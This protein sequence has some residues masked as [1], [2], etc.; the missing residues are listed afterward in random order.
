MMLFLNVTKYVNCSMVQGLNCSIVVKPQLSLILTGSGS[1]LKVDSVF[2][3]SEVG[4]M[5]T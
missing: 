1:Q 2:Y 5:S 3:P 4:K